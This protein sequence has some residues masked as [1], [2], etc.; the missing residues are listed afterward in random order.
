MS[1][2]LDTLA[3]ELE[4]PRELPAQ[5][6]NHLASTYDIGR[7][8]IGRFLTADLLKLEDYE[9]DLILSPVFTPT[10]ND[11]AIFAEL[12]GRDSIPTQEW[13]ALVGQLF[14]R[15]THAQLVTADGLTHTVPLREVSIE[16][17]VHRLRLDGTV[18]GALFKLIDHLAPIAD[19]PLLKAVARRAIWNDDARQQI[20]VRYL[21][22]TVGADSYLVDD[23]PEVLRLAETYQPSDTADLLARIPRWQQVLRHG[24]DVA[25]DPKPFFNERVQE[26]HGG[27][28]DQRPTER[29]RINAKQSELAFLDRL[30][31]IMAG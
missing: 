17:Y 29:S 9:I 27:G 21:T 24:I 10:L 15:P 2:L 19:R 20:L 12:L 4:R 5:V 11:Q 13:P 23:V 3:K 7:D 31:Q 8:A 6:A 25:A 30:K 1:S 18:P 16:R 26:L 14:S 22:N 28:R